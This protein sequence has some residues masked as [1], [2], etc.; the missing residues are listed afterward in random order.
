MF[1]FFSEFLLFQRFLKKCLYVVVMGVVVAKAAVPEGRREAKRASG[2]HSTLRKLVSPLKKQKTLSAV[3]EKEGAPT[4][5]GSAVSNLRTLA[6]FPQHPLNYLSSVVPVLE[7][8][9]KAFASSA[10]F[11]SRTVSCR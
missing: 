1:I 6:P 3:S 4:S 11:C 9:K 8:R 5:F 7:K 2:L 10:V